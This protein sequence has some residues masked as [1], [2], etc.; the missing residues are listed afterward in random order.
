[1]YK[2][3]LS[4]FMTIVIVYGMLLTHPGMGNAFAQPELSTPDE[5]SMLSEPLEDIDT[6][7]QV[8][9]GEGVMPGATVLVYRHG[10]IV[11]QDGYGYDAKYEDD[12][13]TEMDDPVEMEESNIFDMAS[14]SKLFTAVSVMQLWDQ[15]YFDLD[16]PMA[17]YLPE[18]DTSEK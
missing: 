17:D 12:E 5:E 15:G 18:Y 16:D 11:K 2:R 4:V 3:I 6:V 14:I 10:N 1:M 9:I 8:G 7:A 13:F